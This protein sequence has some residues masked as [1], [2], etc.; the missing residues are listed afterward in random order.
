MSR[1]IRTKVFKGVSSKKYF[2]GKIFFNVF[3][4]V[5]LYTFWIYK[6]DCYNI[7]IGKIFKTR[8]LYN[9][10]PLLTLFT[11]STTASAAGDLSLSWKPCGCTFGDVTS[12]ASTRFSLGGGSGLGGATRRFY[13]FQSWWWSGYN[14]G[15]HCCWT[16]SRYRYFIE[17]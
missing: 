15:I 17:Q 16:D 1:C 7:I 13:W 5:C 9:L 3:L 11:A 14:D 4:N 12:T 10:F 6:D 2:T 8:F